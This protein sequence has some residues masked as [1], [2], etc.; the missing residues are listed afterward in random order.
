MSFGEVF[1]LIS[2]ATLINMLLLVI[3]VD[4]Q[5][6]EP[7]D[8]VLVFMIFLIPLHKTPNEEGNMVSLC[9]S[10]NIIISLMH[11]YRDWV[12]RFDRRWHF[13]YLTEQIL[14]LEQYPRLLH[15]GPRQVSQYVFFF[16]NES[17]SFPSALQTS[18][19]LR[20]ETRRYV[21]T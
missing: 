20:S 19:T 10:F 3:P 15:K 17:A 12:R 5:S 14:G 8:I 2:L 16:P 9:S 21:V 13:A 11:A 18:F 6:S 4:S 7:Q 1:A